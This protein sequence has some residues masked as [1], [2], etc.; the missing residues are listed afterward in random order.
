MNYA[1][2]SGMRLLALFRYWNMIEYFFPYKHLTDNVPTMIT[3]IGVYYPDGR[4][5]Q[6]VGIAIDVEVKPTIQG[7]ID[8]KDELLEKALEIIFQ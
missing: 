8:G 3:G 5:I 6:R 2:D 1:D 4:E 7:I